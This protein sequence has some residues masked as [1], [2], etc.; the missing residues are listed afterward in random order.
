M[1]KLR[2]V[3][4]HFWDD[5]FVIQLDP[6]EKLLF[7]Y[8]LTNPLANISGAYEISLRRVAF[9]TGIDQ[10]MILK[11]LHRFEAADKIIYRDGWLFIVNFIKNQ[12]LNPKIVAGIQIAAKRCPDWIKHRLSIAYPS[13]CIGFDNSNSNSNSNSNGA[14]APS[15]TATPPVAAEDGEEVNASLRTVSSI[16]NDRFPKYRLSIAQLELL[17]PEV[18]DLEIWDAAVTGWALNGYSPRNIDGLLDKYRQLL[19]RKQTTPEEDRLPTAA[20][21]EAAREEIRRNF[22]RNHLPTTWLQNVNAPK[23]L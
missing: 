16:Y 6:I 19:H 10:E 21:A 14:I 18:S 22:D 2:S 7:L 9:D 8:F 15:T 12:S 3:N 5:T 23:P 20:E 13:L 17:E 4:T 11:I 1:S